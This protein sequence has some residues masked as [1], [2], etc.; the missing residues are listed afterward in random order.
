VRS[1]ELSARP[2][3]ESP[4]STPSPS[5]SNAFQLKYFSANGQ[6]SSLLSVKREPMTMP[7]YP[8]FGEQVLCINIDMKA[9]AFT[10]NY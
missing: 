9:L 5:P 6:F 8:F 7:D 2:S 10:R 1:F 3:G 4:T